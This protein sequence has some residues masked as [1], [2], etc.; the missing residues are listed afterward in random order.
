MD[1]QWVQLAYQ[2]V[3]FISLC[4]HCST[5]LYLIISPILR[6]NVIFLFYYLTQQFWCWKLFSRET[7]GLIVLTLTS[8]IVK[9][10]LVISRLGNLWS[11]VLCTNSSN[12]YS[13]HPKIVVILALVFN[14]H[15]QIV[16]NKSRHIYKTHTSNIVWIYYLSKTNF[17]FGWIEYLFFKY[18]MVKS[19]FFHSKL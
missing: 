17:N 16:N 9:F 18:C 7:S 6:N 13:L 12:C 15:I 1:V 14:I 4:N 10:Y 11:C 19:F 8:S 5:L 2:T 3:L